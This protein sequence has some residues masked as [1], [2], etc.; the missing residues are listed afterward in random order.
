MENNEVVELRKIPL[1][2]F[3]DILTEL[4]DKGADYVDIIAKP[5]EEQDVISLVVKQEYIDPDNNRFDEDI[6]IYP[7]ETPLSSMDLNSL[8]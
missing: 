4:H 8:I 7:K 2:G 1:E 3:I 6:T 5:N